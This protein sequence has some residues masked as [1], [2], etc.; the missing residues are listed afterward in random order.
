MKILAFI[1]LF[2]ASWMSAADQTLVFMRHGEKP[3]NQSGV[4][5]CQGL[6]R[7]LALPKIL[8]KFGKPNAIFAAAPKQ[9]KLGN[10]IRS[11]Q[12]ILP[13]ATVNSVPIHLNYHANEVSNVK[14]ALL[15][16]AYKNSVIFV[17]WEHENLVKIVRAI[18]K[19]KKGDPKD[20]PDWKKEDFD[21][22]YILKLSEKQ[23]PIFIKSAQNL[24]NLSTICPN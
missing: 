5:T 4:L 8:A 17:T 16:N 13:T 6:N 15:A 23:S 3:N 18:Y 12:T 9:N 14:N 24:N 20:I 22:L 7:S 2:F 11:V 19:Q 10:S 21:S 1:L